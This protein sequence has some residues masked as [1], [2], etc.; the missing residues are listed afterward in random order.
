MAACAITTSTT[1]AAQGHDPLAY[2]ADVPANQTG[3]G[4]V[5]VAPALAVQLVLVPPSAS[6]LPHAPELALMLTRI[7]LGGVAINH[8]VIEV[9]PVS[10]TAPMEPF[11]DRRNGAS[12]RS[13]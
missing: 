4:R 12:G 9:P 10:P 7:P 5:A 13:A 11:R 6:H 3:K 8:V 1:E 2:L